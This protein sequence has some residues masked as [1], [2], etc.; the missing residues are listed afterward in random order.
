LSYRGA[1]FRE[2]V[3]FSQELCQHAFVTVSYI[4]Q[5]PPPKPASIVHG[6]QL[7][8]LAS[9]LLGTVKMS[10]Q[11]PENI[12]QANAF[13]ELMLSAHLISLLKLGTENIF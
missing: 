11:V 10:G 5:T 6:K 4:S 13:A 3:F 1:I 2:K 7:S 9:L 12:S 8:L